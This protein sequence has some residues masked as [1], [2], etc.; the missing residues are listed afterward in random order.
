MSACLFSFASSV[1]LFAGEVFSLDSEV[2]SEDERRETAAAHA[3]QVRKKA[4]LPELEL[5]ALP[6]TIASKMLKL[7]AVHTGVVHL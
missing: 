3:S 1:V 5:D 2:N 4:G 7:A 6:S